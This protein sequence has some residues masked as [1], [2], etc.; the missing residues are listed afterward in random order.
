MTR[1][2]W[3]PD[4]RG[5]TAVIVGGGPSA[6]DAPLSLARG[7]ARVIVINNSWQLCPWADLLYA[8][9]T[10]WWRQY[11]AAVAD[12]DG[13]RVSATPECREFDPTVHVVSVDTDSPH[14]H[15]ILMDPP[16][17]L[18]NGR[19]GGFQAINLAAQLGSRRLVLVGYDMHLCN[20]LHWHGA[21]PKGMNNPRPELVKRWAQ[22][23][24][25]VAPQLRD[26]GIEVLSA[27]PGSAL[28]AYPF[29][30]LGAALPC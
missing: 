12:F 18:G 15:S 29:V 24:D 13:I 10:L 25:A 27:T 23:L 14:K 9:D 21:H 20:G 5:Q 26:L 16:G 6:I 30:E 3:F 28:R 11:A 22:L 7:R 8:A 4:W 17:R 1:P 19:N 2:A